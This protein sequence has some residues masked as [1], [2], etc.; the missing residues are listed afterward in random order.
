MPYLAVCYPKLALNQKTE[1][2]GGVEIFS[3]I[4][5]M[6]DVPLH[7]V[8][9]SVADKGTLTQTREEAFQAWMKQQKEQD[10]SLDFATL[11]EFVFTCQNSGSGV[12]FNRVSYRR[13]VQDEDYFGYAVY[14]RC[15]DMIHTVLIEVPLAA[16]WRSTMFFRSYLG[17]IVIFA[18]RRAPEFWEGTSDYKKESSIEE[19]FNE[20]KIYQKRKSP[21]YW[22]KIH[23]YLISALIK[24]KQ[25]GDEKS[26]ENAKSLL[27]KLRSEQREW[28]NTQKL[29]YQLADKNDKRQ[30]MNSIQAMASSI[31]TP[32]FQQSDY[33][34]ELIKRKDWK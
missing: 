3:A 17:S 18:A 29:A 15:E 30:T 2:E 28:Y 11:Q 7:I 16:Q 5:K 9:T 8:A 33:R 26:L 10:S 1:V 23:Y 6:R 31:F 25:K 19:D 13:R 20:V 22:E 32:E 21:V 24:A 4:G 27:A 14:L 34:Y 12:P